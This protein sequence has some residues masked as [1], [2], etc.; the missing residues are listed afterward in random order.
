MLRITRPFPIER[1]ATYGLMSLAIGFF[2]TVSVLMAI[3]RPDIPAPVTAGG[4][5]GK[6]EGAATRQMPAASGVSSSTTPGETAKN[7][8]GTWEALHGDPSSATITA[9]PA[10][11]SSASEPVAASPVQTTT[12]VSGTTLPTAPVSVSETEPNLLEVQT[13][14]PLVETQ[15]DAGTVLTVGF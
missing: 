11:G 13:D 5:V 2:G 3:M 14:L 6:I 15:V 12:D 7:A 10:T 8:T 1:A 9:A 4:N